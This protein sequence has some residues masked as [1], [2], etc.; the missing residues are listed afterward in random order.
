MNAT[1]LNVVQG[2]IQDVRYMLEP[3]ARDNRPTITQRIANFF[4]KWTEASYNSW[5]RSKI[6]HL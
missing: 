3:V 5:E 2:T 6:Q 4:D 1:S